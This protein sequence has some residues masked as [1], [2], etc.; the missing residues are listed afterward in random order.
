[1]SM[2]IEFSLVFE[3]AMTRKEWELV[4]RILKLAAWCVS[5]KAGV[6]PNETSSAAAV[7]FYEDLAEKRDYWQYFPKWFSPRMFM[8]LRE[9][10]KYS[11]NPTVLTELVDYYES[12]AGT[13]DVA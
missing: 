8:T 2:W 4:D 6:L 9:V 11:L 13:G 7:A 12:H 3:D 5:E 1:M 10:F